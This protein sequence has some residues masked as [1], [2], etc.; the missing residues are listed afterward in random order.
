[1]DHAARDPIEA[2]RDRIPVDRTERD[3]FQDQQVQLALGRFD[4]VG[5]IAITS[6]FYILDKHV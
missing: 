4:F 6:F 1:L 2:L 5:F 3:N